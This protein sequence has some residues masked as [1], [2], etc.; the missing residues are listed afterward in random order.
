MTSQVN[1]PAAV[2]A[3]E[4]I[5]QRLTEQ[6]GKD[7]NSAAEGTKRKSIK[8]LTSAV[9]PDKLRFLKTDWV[10]L[11]ATALFSIWITGGFSS[12]DVVEDRAI[13]ECPEATV[14]QV[15]RLGQPFH[16]STTAMIQVKPDTEDNVFTAPLEYFYRQNNEDIKDTFTKISLAS[17]L[18]PIGDS[19]FAAIEIGRAHV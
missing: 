18:L 3:G 15:L 6:Q 14:Q 13:E 16:T 12:G 7:Y 19:K 2:K 5:A 4:D 9:D 11:P 8:K 17:P 10:K 1:N